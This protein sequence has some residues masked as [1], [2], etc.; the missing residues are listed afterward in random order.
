MYG[1]VASIR[2]TKFAKFS[3]NVGWC[4]VVHTFIVWFVIIYLEQFTENLMWKYKKNRIIENILKSVAYKCTSSMYEYSTVDWKRKMKRMNEKE[5]FKFNGIYRRKLTAIL[6][7]LTNWSQSHWVII[8]VVRIVCTISSNISITITVTITICKWIID[9]NWRSNTIDIAPSSILSV[10]NR[11]IEWI[12]AKR[13]SWRLWIACP[14]SNRKCCGWGKNYFLI[15]LWSGWMWCI[16]VIKVFLN[17]LIR[18]F[19]GFDR[20]ISCR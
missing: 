13:F 17:L 10:D 20:T 15:E 6:G 4:T 14:T 1:R 7:L 8:R 9:C 12:I 11:R 3:L 5:Q 16:C 18:K 2:F 19:R